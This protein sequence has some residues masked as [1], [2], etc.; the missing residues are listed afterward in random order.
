MPARASVTSINRLCKKDKHF[1]TARNRGIGRRLQSLFF[2]VVVG[3]RVA[4]GRGRAHIAEGAKS[5][6]GAIPGREFLTRVARDTPFGS[7]RKFSARYAL[8][9]HLGR[10]GP[11][12]VRTLPG[13]GCRGAAPL[14]PGV[15]GCP[16]SVV[17][18][19]RV[20]SLPRKGKKISGYMCM[21]LFNP[22]ALFT[23]ST[24]FSMKLASRAPLNQVNMPPDLEGLRITRA[25]SV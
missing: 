9:L 13:R 11:G 16:L 21:P 22:S 23:F 18:M 10:R 14:L 6:R 25:S 8:P 5:A 15:R 7:A 17:G 3:V 2:G 4:P 12:G 1:P 19:Y 24:A 20:S